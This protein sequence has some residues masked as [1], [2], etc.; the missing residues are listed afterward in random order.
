[1]DRMNGGNAAW[2]GD[3]GGIAGAG[4]DVEVPGCTVI[5]GCIM[6]PLVLVSMGTKDDGAL[7]TTSVTLFRLNILV[8]GNGIGN[9]DFDFSFLPLDSI[10][11]VG[12]DEL[13]PLVS[14]ET[15]GTGVEPLAS[16]LTGRVTEIRDMDESSTLWPKSDADGDAT[17]VD[18]LV[19]AVDE[20]AGFGRRSWSLLKPGWWR[21]GRDAGVVLISWLTKERP[22]DGNVRIWSTKI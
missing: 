22:K 16:M 18:P 5:L 7:D 3:L 15:F 20:R 13:P 21:F 19:L 17:P 11:D 6:G 1:M 10:S 9:D 8:P 12:A 4:P 2:R 14:A